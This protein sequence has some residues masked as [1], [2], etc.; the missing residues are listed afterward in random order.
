M[1]YA[2]GSPPHVCGED[3]H[4]Y[5][6]KLSKEQRIELGKHRKGENNSFFG[7]HHNEKTRQLIGSYHKGKIISEAHKLA[8]QEK[9]IKR[10]GLS[11][12]LI[13]PTG[14]EY[15]CHGIRKYCKMFNLDRASI[16]KLL[17][18]QYTNFKGWTDR[19]SVV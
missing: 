8:T 14:E 9:H 11:F 10:I 5:G 15:I 13:S 6:K 7:K 16:T 3:H 18:G 19:K 4:L 17:R 1:S 12:K 2:G